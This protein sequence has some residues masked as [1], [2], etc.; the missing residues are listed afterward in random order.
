[1]K[2]YRKRAIFAKNVLKITILQPSL[3]LYT[4]VWF[5]GYPKFGRFG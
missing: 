5:K 1:V 3:I 4:L 2:K